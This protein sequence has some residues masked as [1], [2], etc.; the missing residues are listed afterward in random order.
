[1]VVFQCLLSS[2]WL[3]DTCMLFTLFIQTKKETNRKSETDPKI[4]IRRN[5]MIRHQ[6]RCTLF[7]SALI[8]I[9]PQK[10]TD[11]RTPV[12]CGTIIPLE[13]ARQKVTLVKIINSLRK[14]FSGWKFTQRSLLL[15]FY[16]SCW[17]VMCFIQPINKFHF[18]AGSNTISA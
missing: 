17:A 3:S 2:Q 12:C 7:N 5:S 18:T 6:I 4:I 11:L 13:F 1:M 16:W 15:Y 10:T 8:K 9:S 14:I